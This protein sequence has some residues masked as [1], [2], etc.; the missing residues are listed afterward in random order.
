MLEGAERVVKTRG[1]IYTEPL[2]SARA[3]E[4][5]AFESQNRKEK[6]RSERQG[7]NGWP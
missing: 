3:E 5:F 7:R 1:V 6:K 2:L 4:F